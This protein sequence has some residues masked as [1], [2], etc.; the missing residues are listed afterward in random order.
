MRKKQRLKLE[1]GKEYKVQLYPQEGIVT[2][3]YIG[4]TQTHYLFGCLSDGSVVSVDKHWACLER[5]I[6]THDS[7]SS[8]AV[9]KSK[10][11]EVRI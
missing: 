5:K 9:T 1:I 8:F 6:I 11:R 4:D 7:M 10:L 3:K 2:G